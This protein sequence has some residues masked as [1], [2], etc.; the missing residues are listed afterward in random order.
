MAKLPTAAVSW[1]AVTL[2]C[3]FE[4][5]WLFLFGEDRGLRQFDLPTVPFPG[6]YILQ[7]VEY[8]DLLLPGLSCFQHLR[9][10]G[11]I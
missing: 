3:T 5:R 9:S 10:H 1:F 7:H 8:R 2:C 11:A 4:S 6:A